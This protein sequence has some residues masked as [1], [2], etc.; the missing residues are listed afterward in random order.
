[1]RY[2]K[3]RLLFKWLGEMN[4]SAVKSAFR[5][6]TWVGVPELMSGGLQPPVIPAL[7]YLMPSSGL[8][9]HLYTCNIHIKIQ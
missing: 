1:M 2:I 8:C 3:V 7:V 5:Q 9:G 6:R 4:K